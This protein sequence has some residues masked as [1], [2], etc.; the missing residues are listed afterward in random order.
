MRQHITFNG[1]VLPG[2]LSTVYSRCGKPKCACKARPPRLHGPYNRWTGFIDGRRT[3][4]TLSR[5]AAAE[6]RRRIRNYRRLQKHIDKL[7]QE[8]LARAPW[9]SEAENARKGGKK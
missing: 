2:S 5:K 9:V 4:K 6:C 8:A 7:L 1:P 3:T